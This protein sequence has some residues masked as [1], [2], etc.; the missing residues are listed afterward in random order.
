M[1]TSCK[2]ARRFLHA[3]DPSVAPRVA[4]HLNECKA[5]QADF[6]QKP[7]ALNFA[8]EHAVI[9]PPFPIMAEAN[10]RIVMNFQ[11]SAPEAK[12]TLPTP[13]APG[14][15]LGAPIRRTV[16]SQV[17]HATQAGLDREVVL[18]FITCSAS[19]FDFQLLA[20]EGK[21]LGALNHPNILTVYQTGRWSK[22]I[23]MALEYCPRGSL[24]D[25]LEQEK[26]FSPRAA[27]QMIQKLAQAVMAAHR[28][29]IIHNDIK[30]G[31]ILIGAHREP[32]LAD[33]GLAR[34]L[35][36]DR[37]DNP[38]HP[39]TGTPAYMA[40]EQVRGE[41]PDIRT[42]VH[43]LGLVLY[44]LLTGRSPFCKE[45]QFLT[46]LEVAHTLPLSPEQVRTA[47]PIDLASICM[48]CL[49][50]APH[51]RYQSPRALALDLGR[52]LSGK[53]IRARKWNYREKMIQWVNRNKATAA[54]LSL[55]AAILAASILLLGLMGFQTYQQKEVAIANA[56]LA[57]HYL[58]KAE[59]QA[60]ASGTQAAL[61][62]ME[63]GLTA[64]AHQLLNQIPF[65][66]RGW[67]HHYLT[68]RLR[69]NQVSL[70][71]HAG[72]VNA[73]AN[74]PDGR[75][76]ISV[77]SDRSVRVWDG[78]E[79][80]Q[81]RNLLGGNHSFV[82]AVYSA[83]GRR[84]AVVDASARVRILDTRSET[85]LPE[86]QLPTIFVNEK[87]HLEPLALSLDGSL[88]YAQDD[89]NRVLEWRV[90]S[91]MPLRAFLPGH[92]GRVHAMVL[93]PD[94]RFL[95]T[96]GEDNKI[97]VWNLVQGRLEREINGNQKGCRCLAISGNGKYLASS[98]KEKKVRLWD[99]LTGHPIHTL[100][101]HDDW[102]NTL[103]FD[104]TGITLAS[105]GDDHVIRLWNVWNGSLLQSLRGHLDLVNQVCF[106]SDGT[107]LFSASSDNTIKIWN[108]RQPMDLDKLPHG[109]SVR[110]LAF[111]PCGSTIATADF[112]NKVRLWSA[113]GKTQLAEIS[114]LSSRISRLCF[115]PDG[116]WVVVAG[117]SPALKLVD[118]KKWIIFKELTGGNASVEDG[119]FS[120]G[121]NRFFSIDADN[122]LT[123]W[124][125]GSWRP[126][127]STPLPR[128]VD[129]KLALSSD[130]SL[131]AAAGS[132]KTIV[133]L[134]TRDWSIRWKLEASQAKTLGLDFSP[135]GSC[136]A[137]AGSDRDIRI[138]DMKTGG[139]VKALE[140]HTMPVTS[141]RYSP[142]GNR[143]LS[144]SFDRSIRL[145]D[146]G[147][148]TEIITLPNHRSNV[149]QAT[150][151]PDGQWIASAGDDN[152]V[153]LWDGTARMEEYRLRQFNTLSDLGEAVDANAKALSKENSTWP[154]VQELI[155][156]GSNKGFSLVRNGQEYLIIN[157]Q[158][159]ET[160]MARE[161]ELL[162]SWE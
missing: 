131:L 129:R 61:Y 36:E 44:Q 102:V 123:I 85:W 57:N 108:P 67:E 2:D 110:A 133:V 12:G 107:K 20:R 65:G 157:R 71:G 154:S 87:P 118:V 151:S 25:W 144:S 132:G 47:I 51:D 84:L 111:S 18:K 34:S 46:F 78:S 11:H 99:F 136:L 28:I 155:G 39:L 148:G 134:N 96:A 69:R 68:G 150:F 114:N 153:L 91:G 19:L 147:R 116:K 142:D 106:S 60:Y 100:E 32:L 9:L 1:N 27:A 45:S 122:T 149:R 13:F 139:M 82:N 138:W 72:P 156:P 23:W 31:N 66:M 126:L 77:S 73:L 140:G 56:R 8:F 125:T 120:P 130:G 83:D 33:F 30:P 79:A 6:E 49:A 5:C 55:S 70:M 37:H 62:E 75:N 15:T 81:V 3:P 101:G 113:C 4:Q 22:G 146:P 143:L 152:Q 63:T 94:G 38:G 160:R 24:A 50:K 89:Q 128:G 98:G 53:P 137:S 103:A 158:A 16:R 29:G 124:D 145:W 43:A 21:I 64:T 159:R 52:F 10:R 41:L 93:S 59:A 35:A 127:N 90:D 17:F 40:P 92:R 95:V 80:I 54:A 117:G 141:V 119:C 97:L 115:S 104:P 42:D 76:F 14:Y 86:I 88:L 74:H 109:N 161:R 121:G 162:H 112:D 7:E 26:S 105:A 135:D 58:D 48:R